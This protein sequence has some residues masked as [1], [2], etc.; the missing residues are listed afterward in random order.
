[1]G[2]GTSGNEG[3]AMG[4]SVM[5]VGGAKAMRWCTVA[6][7]VMDVVKADGV[8]SGGMFTSVLAMDGGSPQSPGMA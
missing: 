5:D 3:W 7:G 1:M 8:G 4:I 2:C 6:S